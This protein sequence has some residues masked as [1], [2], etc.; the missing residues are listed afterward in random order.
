[1]HGGGVETETVNREAGVDSRASLWS[2]C[3]NETRCAESHYCS[4]TQMNSTLA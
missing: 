3:F 4:M 1:M 2:E